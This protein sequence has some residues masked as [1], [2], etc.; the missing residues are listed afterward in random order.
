MEVKIRAGGSS[1]G[2]FEGPALP[3]FGFTGTLLNTQGLCQLSGCPQN[4]DETSPVRAF[5]RVSCAV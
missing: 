4:T 1:C 5:S 3:G 2:G